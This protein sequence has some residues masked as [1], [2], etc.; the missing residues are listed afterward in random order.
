MA[1]LPTRIFAGSASQVLGTR[2]ATACGQHLGSLKLW[3]F[4]DG[5][6]Y[7]V[8]QEPIR[9]VQVVLI[10]ATYP[11]AEHSMEL[12]LMIDAAKRA[13]ACQVIVVAPYLGYMRQDK[14][15]DLGGSIGARLQANLLTTAGAD[16]LLA[17]DPHT[18]KLSS[19]FRGPVDQ[20]TS[21]PVFVPY[22]NKLALKKLVFAAPDAG[23]MSRVEC[24]AQHFGTD[25]VVCNKQ[26]TGPNEIA[27]VHVTG[28][29]QGAD[30][31]L[32]D[33]IVDTGHTLCKAA[34]QLQIQG[35]RS[36]R[37]LCTHPILSGLAYQNLEASALEE[38]VVTDTI[39][40]KQTSSKINLVSMAIPF[41]EAIQQLT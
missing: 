3:R 19:F 40:L 2:I 33:D 25:L 20:L 36:V 17:C 24:Y 39:P 18:E 41:A 6:L 38:L 32:V 37:A 4:S 13:G 5:E 11:P 30:V 21:L 8:F 31:I 26:R 27:K 12:L 1:S 22:I 34:E 15:H 9:D 35:A 10:Q 23:G 16:R 7:P 29:I 28:N 14:A